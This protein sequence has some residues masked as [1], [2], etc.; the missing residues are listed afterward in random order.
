RVISRALANLFAGVASLGLFAQTPFIP[1]DRYGEDYTGSY[2]LIPNMGQVVDM[3]GDPDTTVEAYTQGSRP[4]LFMLDGGQMSIAWH[5]TDTI[6]ATLDTIWSLRFEPYGEGV[7]T[8]VE[9]WLHS[10]KTSFENFYLPQCLEGITEVYG[11]NHVVW[12]NVFPK[13]DQHLYSG[14]RGWKMSF[15]VRPGGNPSDL[16]YKFHGQDS[17]G[18]D[19]FG[20]LRVVLD[21][22]WVVLPEAVAYQVDTNGTIL[23]LNWT[24]DYTASNNAGTVGFVV[25]AYDTTKALILHIGVPPMM[26]GGPQTPGTCWSTYWGGQANNMM[27]AVATDKDANLYVAGETNSP[28]LSFPGGVDVGMQLYFGNRTIV[29]S[30]VDPGHVPDWTTYYGANTLFQWPDRVMPDD[31]GNVYMVGKCGASFNLPQVGI[32]YPWSQLA[33]GFISRFNASSGALQWSTGFNLILDAAVDLDDDQ[34]VVVGY[35]SPVTPLFEPPVQPTGS[36]YYP[37]SGGDPNEAY[38]AKFRPSGELEWSTYIGG[39]GWDQAWSVAA[40]H[41]QIVVALRTLSDDIP[42]V[43]PAG[44]NAY[45]QAYGITSS[46]HGVYLCRFTADGVHEWGSYYGGSE[47]ESVFQECVDIDPANG[48]FV[49]VG[50]TTSPDLPIVPGP[51]WYIG[52]LGNPTTVGSFITRFSGQDDE[53]VWSTYV[54]PSNAP[55]F[56]GV[57]AWFPRFGANQN[58]YIAGFADS[59][60]FDWVQAPNLYY[61]ETLLNDR[62]GFVLWFD[63]LNTLRW[64]TLFGGAQDNYEENITSIA[65]DR[66]NHVLYATGYS[67]ANLAAGQFFPLTDPGPPAYFRAIA[68]DPQDSF[69][70]AFCMDGFT[71]VES[72]VKPET[73]AR[74]FTEGGSQIHCVGFAAGVY[75]LRVV[76]MLG[77]VVHQSRLAMH[78]NGIQ[79]ITPPEMTSGLYVVTVGEAS[80]RLRF[81]Q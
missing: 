7:N 79:S 42:I 16:V 47:S 54:R 63:N 57:L 56:L 24:A 13:I 67:T 45:A 51:G 4:Q 12:E 40:G 21:D 5:S 23:P 10:E 35:T 33:N 68:V 75:D 6:E 36:T 17:L 39:A 1:P 50:R 81:T 34:L 9:P 19:V 32:T 27:H 38:V 43:T 58:L 61:S 64:S 72:Q 3:N 15:V 73:S 11:Y 59:D 26:G 41:G 29:L 70:S 48:D 80:V 46:S 60:L 37:H 25:D 65:Y 18:V 78:G 74:L 77:R 31:L 53:L 28:F 44:G 76:D 52:S 62:D 22:K 49:V 71:G 8:N 20:F 2:A 14:P 66:T 55:N 30:K 69:I